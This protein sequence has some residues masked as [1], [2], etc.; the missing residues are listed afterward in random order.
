LFELDWADKAKESYASL[1]IDASK[2]KRYK[3]VKKAI[4]QIAKDP[5]YPS[6]QSHEFTSLKGAN[7]EKVF[8]SYA[9]N[10][11]PGAYRILW[12]YGQG[13]GVITIFLITPHP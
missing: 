11:T 9:E 7:G 4:K 12:H 6:L 2:E 5:R 8:E 1:R 10:N 3:A 13:K